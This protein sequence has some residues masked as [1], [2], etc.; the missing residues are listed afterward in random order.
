MSAS[1]SGA[2]TVGG[3]RDA[4]IAIKTQPCFREFSA[5]QSFYR[6][7]LHFF[8]FPSVSVLQLAL[9]GIPRLLVREAGH[10]IVLMS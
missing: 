7:E 6:K 9:L 1:Q 4:D 10:R 5:F 2:W 8:S 3:E